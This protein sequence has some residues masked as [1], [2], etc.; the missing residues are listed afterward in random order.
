MHS[1]MTRMLFPGALALLLAGCATPPPPADTARHGPDGDSGYFLSWRQKGELIGTGLIRDGRGNQYDIWIV[2]GYVVPAHRMAKYIGHTGD[3]FAEYF[4]SRKYHDLAD[5]SGDCFDWAYHD[6]LVKFVYKGVPQAWGDDLHHAGERT[7]KRVFGWWFAY[8]WAVLEGTVDTV[9]RVPLGLTGAALGTASGAVV[10]PAFHAVDSTVKGAAEFGVGAIA[11]PV[12]ACAWNTVI[13]PPMALVGQKPAPSR[14]DGYWVTMQTPP[15]QA[16]HA[17]PQ[18]TAEDIA[19]LTRWGR[20]LLHESQA[21][22][23]RRQQASQ[24]RQDLL[25]TAEA[26]YQTNLAT[27][28]TAEQARISAAATAPALRD[29]LRELSQRGFDRERTAAAFGDV[30]KR[31]RSE[32][33]PSPEIWRIRGLLT[34]HPPATMTNLPPVVVRDKTDPL[35]QS[36]HVI[37][38]VPDHAPTGN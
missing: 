16:R 23:A 33:V 6:C 27:L 20:A 18:A 34:R 28:A 15:E 2:P 31:L 37:E 36:L 10:V 12:V 30:E 3:D 35:Q 38:H 24:E 26:Q 7:D 21:L 8:P 11:G 22:D 14:V 5:D 17:L 32:G 9:V 13:A 1:T 19:A 29:Q 4:G 25:R